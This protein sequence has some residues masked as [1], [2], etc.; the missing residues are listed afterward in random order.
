MSLGV[1][2]AVVGTVSKLARIEA[3]TESTRARP[4]RKATTRSGSGLEEERR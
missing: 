2:D 1:P 3:S 4:P